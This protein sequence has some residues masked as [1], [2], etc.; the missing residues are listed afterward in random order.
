MALLLML[1]ALAVAAAPP[2]LA[3]PSADDD[4]GR[5]ACHGT[6]TTAASSMSGDPLASDCCDEDCPHMA[7]CMLGHLSLAETPA[8]PVFASVQ[9]HIA[10]RTLTLPPPRGSPRLRPPISLHG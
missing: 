7:A 1:Q 2:A 8:M 4:T 6:A 9:L 3:A 5:P 10:S